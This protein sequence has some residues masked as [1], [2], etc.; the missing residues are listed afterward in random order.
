MTI[1]HSSTI[2]F[3]C[4]FLFLLVISVAYEEVESFRGTGTG[5]HLSVETVGSMETTMRQLIGS[6]CLL[7]EKGTVPPYYDCLGCVVEEAQGCVDDMRYNKSGQVAPECN[8]NSAR[9]RYDGAQCC[10][11]FGLML[12]PAFNQPYTGGKNFGRIDMQVPGSA[13]PSALRCIQASGCGEHVIYQQLRQECSSAC[14]RIRDARSNGRESVCDSEFNAAP[15]GHLRL[16]QVQH[17]SVLLGT[18]L[19]STLLLAMFM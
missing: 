7:I 8:L 10:P 11:K 18:V 1:V 17:R 19:A 16:F 3:V 6:N 2:C 5:R 12:D 4:T 14:A 9:E 13:Y 15:P